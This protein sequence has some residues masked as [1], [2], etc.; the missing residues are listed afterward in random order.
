M[1]LLITGGAGFIGSHLGDRLIQE[2]HEVVVI[3]NLST[4]KKENVHLK[5]RFYSIDI[6]A[7]GISHIF[8]KEKFDVV[9][10][11]AAQIDVRKSVENPVEDA[12]INILGALNILENCRKLTTKK[13]IFASSGG[14]IYGETDIIPTPESFPGPPISPYGISKL[15][16]EKYLDYYYKVFGLPY[17]SLRLANVYGSRQDPTG[18]AGVMGVFID[19]MLQ[20]KQPII[21]G[22]GRQTRDF[23]FIDDVVE[24]NLLVLK[25]NKVGIFNIGTT[26][27]T[28]INTLFRKLKN[29]TRANCEKVYGPK[30]PRDQKRSCLNFQK[31]N[32]EIGWKP[33]VSLE[34]GLQKTV[35]WFVKQK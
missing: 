19:R 13:I 14:A 25:S 5:A 4:G 7:Q 8:Q 32:Q 31:A 18:E 29:I 23:I 35:E 34:E 9:F 2:G 33:K 3:D 27:E 10:H 20:E 28:D 22:D 24:A 6:R 16:T 26:K 17:V 12:N 1:K 30:R 21:N 15:A 11:Y